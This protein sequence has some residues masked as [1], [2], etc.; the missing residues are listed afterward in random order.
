MSNEPYT[1][2]T[3]PNIADLLKERISKRAFDVI[4][5]IAQV[6]KT[7]LDGYL[8]DELEGFI[9][10]K[11]VWKYGDVINNHN[12]IH[13]NHV[14]EHEWVVPPDGNALV[15]QIGDAPLN[16]ALIFETDRRVNYGFPSNK[17]FHS[18][19]LNQ[20]M[21]EHRGFDFLSQYNKVTYIG[22]ITSNAQL[23]NT[24]VEE[25]RDEMTCER[26]GINM[27]Q[28]KNRK[29]YEKL[30][31]SLNRL[32]NAYIKRA[33]D[34]LSEFNRGEKHPDVQIQFFSDV[35]LFTVKL[36]WL[37][38]KMT[39]TDKGEVSY[40]MPVLNDSFNDIRTLVNV[41]F[42]HLSSVGSWDINRDL[43][44]HM[45]GL[46]RIIVELSREILEYNKTQTGEQI[47][48]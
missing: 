17:W 48:D 19:D 25:V 22:G 5:D 18:S 40:H 44:E 12:P 7:M 46:E 28:L 16:I 42:S 2:I 32:K 24:I 43:Q 8:T 23:L 30:T 33:V 47:N 37:S 11:K 1:T 15:V 14:V 26:D 39:V 21:G 4:N 35:A 41:R 10:E 45:D 13:K 36:K 6:H 38:F 3:H 29:A 31:S 9:H 20:V 34:S 27:E